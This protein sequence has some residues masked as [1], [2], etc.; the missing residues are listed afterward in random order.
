MSRRAS[1]DE[2][3]AAMRVA[4]KRPSGAKAPEFFGA[5]DG[6]AEAVPFQGGYRKLT[7]FR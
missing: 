5:V 1:K 2:K 4:E 7:K 6:T 3:S